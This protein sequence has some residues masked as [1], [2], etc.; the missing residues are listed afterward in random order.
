MSH[1]LGAKQPES[2][3]S[4]TI[5][6]LSSSLTCRT[7]STTR[8]HVLWHLRSLVS[9]NKRDFFFIPHFCGGCPMPFTLR[10]AWKKWKGTNQCLLSTIN[11]SNL[12]SKDREN[13]KSLVLTLQKLFCSK[14]FIGVKLHNRSSTFEKGILIFTS[15]Q[16]KTLSTIR[17]PMTFVNV[18]PHLMI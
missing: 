4:C 2:Q 9:C 17:D 8:F 1:D 15:Q 10:N 5:C 18:H 12:H 13:F 14:F 7:F 11:A 3:A 6:Y 16:V